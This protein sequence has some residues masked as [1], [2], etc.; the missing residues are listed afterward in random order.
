MKWSMPTRPLVILTGEKMQGQAVPHR[1]YL[2]LELLNH[3]IK[4]LEDSLMLAQQHIEQATL[5]L[6]ML[7]SL[8]GTKPDSELLVPIGSGAF[9][10]VNAKDVASLKLSVGAGVV[11]EK[12]VDEVVTFVQKRL[13]EAKGLHAQTA[14][15][16]NQTIEK[17]MAL[18]QQIEASLRKEN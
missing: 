14:A 13:E 10:T 16:Y 1:E 17:S 11:V 8:K 6:T 9:I 7:D 15:S 3:Q 5:T 2:E 4:Q 18:Q 12:N